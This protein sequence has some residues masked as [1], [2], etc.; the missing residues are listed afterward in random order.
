MS[1]YPKHTFI[2]EPTTNKDCYYCSKSFVETE[3]TGE[4][5]PDRYYSCQDKHK[6]DSQ[7]DENKKG[8]GLAK[9]HYYT[10]GEHKVI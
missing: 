8:C 10:Q 6:I 4:Y 5:E 3:H 9:G 7:H 1:V 2:G